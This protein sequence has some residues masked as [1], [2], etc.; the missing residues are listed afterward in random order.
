[1]DKQVNKCNALR[2]DRKIYKTVSIAGK[3]LV[4]LLDT[5]SDLHLLKAEEYIKLGAPPLTGP[6]ISC[7][8]LSKDLI[9]ILGS[10]EINV[11]IDNDNFCLPLHV[12]SD[13][14]LSHS[15]LLG[16][17]LLK[18]VNMILTEDYVKVIDALVT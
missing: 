13:I 7:K 6:P 1:M 18:D 15:L 17:G 14:C 12:I 9:T 3:S 5:G 10:F 2:P 8:G 4:A 11:T 16:S